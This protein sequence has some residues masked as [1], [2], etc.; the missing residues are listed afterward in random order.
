M[1]EDLAAAT[2][3]ETHGHRRRRRRLPT[4]PSP[5][6]ERPKRPRLPS[7]SLGL[8][9]NEKLDDGIPAVGRIMRPTGV[10]IFPSRFFW[11][12]WERGFPPRRA[13]AASAGAACM[14]SGGQRAA[15]SLP[16]SPLMRF[17]SLRCGSTGCFRSA[18][19]AQEAFGPPSRRRRVQ[20]SNNSQ[21][22]L[23]HPRNKVSDRTLTPTA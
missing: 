7:S 23:S 3:T 2:A 5:A 15:L 19:W 10:L 1:E 11:V 6:A 20:T 12:E 4:P 22:P 16:P 13:R 18:C 8:S 9:G 17:P 14:I 21:R